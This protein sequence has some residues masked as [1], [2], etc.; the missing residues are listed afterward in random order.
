M[1]EMFGEAWSP[2]SVPDLAPDD[3]DVA[4]IESRSETRASMTVNRQGSETIMNIEHSSN[5][6]SPSVPPILE[7]LMYS[8]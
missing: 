3:D 8:T 2:M 4:A 1:S 6:K 7:Q 5:R